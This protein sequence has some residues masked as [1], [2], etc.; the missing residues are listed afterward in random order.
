MDFQ[1]VGRGEAVVFVED[2]G[3][4]VGLEGEGLGLLEGGGE[5]DGEVGEG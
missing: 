1:G 5:G 3:L 2:D 4:D